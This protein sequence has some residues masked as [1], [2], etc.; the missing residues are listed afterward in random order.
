MTVKEAQ[1]EIKNLEDTIKNMHLLTKYDKEKDNVVDKI[2]DAAG[3]NM[4]WQSIVLHS[5]N[6]MT[7]YKNILKEKIDNAQI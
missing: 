5:V 2:A 3:T 7:A 1:M 6:A 4:I